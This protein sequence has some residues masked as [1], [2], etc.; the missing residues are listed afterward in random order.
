MK[1]WS[2]IPGNHCL[3]GGPIVVRMNNVSGFSLIRK[4]SGKDC[5][6]FEQRDLK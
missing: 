6:V 2:Q 3:G 5:F 4:K 1:W